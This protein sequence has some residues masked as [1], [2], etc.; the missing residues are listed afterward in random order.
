MY[1][2]FKLQ[3]LKENRPDVWERADKFLCF[4]DLLQHRLGIDPAISRSLAGRT[5]MFDVMERRWSDSILDT[6]GLSPKRLARPLASGSIAGK[7]NSK[8]GNELGLAKNAYVVTAG[9]DQPCAALGSGV[10]KAGLAIYTCGTVECITP[11]LDKAVI[12]DELR[13][14][15]FCMYDHVVED[16]YVTL[17]YRLTGG[18]ILKWFRS[19]FAYKEK[20]TASAL[21]KDPY[22][23]IVKNMAENPTDLMV[24]PY[25]VSG[26][27]PH[28]DIHTKGAILGLR[29]S[30]KR[31]EVIRALIEGVAMEMRLNLD[32]LERSGIDINMLR[33]VGGGAKSEKLTHLKANVLGKSITTLQ[34]KETGCYGAAM[35]AYS[36]N[37]KE[38]VYKIADSWVKIVSE[39][40]PDEKERKFY[41]EKFE[42]YVDVYPKIREIKI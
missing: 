18:N 35:L 6:I 4:E 33:I 40:V 34:V 41:D 37:T 5:M 42:R 10:T 11:C 38:S 17:A 31:G 39:I 22:E 24:L 1:T 26:G 8:I 29:L 19:E 14:N 16:K 30:T 12:S 13:K 36:A 23:L 2:L 32:I 25:W 7:I 9:H 21:K 20:E 27:T 28:F 15:N 3:W